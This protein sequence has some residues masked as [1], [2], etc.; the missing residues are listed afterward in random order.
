MD[1]PGLVA[2]RIVWEGTKTKVITTSPWESP[3]KLDGPRSR[4]DHESISQN[5]DGRLSST[6]YCLSGTVLGTLHT[7][8]HSVPIVR[9]YE[10]GTT[11]IP[12]IHIKCW[13]IS[14]KQ[15]CPVGLLGSFLKGRAHFFSCLPPSCNIL[16]HKMKSLTLG[17]EWQ[18]RETKGD[19]IAAYHPETAYLQSYRS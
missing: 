4:Y 19:W 14:R 2:I 15:K 5:T 18:A 8:A 17:M 3:T 7:L 13:P 1:S 16:V 10:V 11:V 6:I 9:P 12:Y